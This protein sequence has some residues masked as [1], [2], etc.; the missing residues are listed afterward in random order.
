MFD[1][2]RNNGMLQLMDASMTLASKR[3]TLIAS[4]LANID[5]PGFHTRDFS[6][7]GA[8]KSALESQAGQQSPAAMKLTQ[9]GHQSPSASTSLPPSEDPIW[10][11]WER[12][13]GNDV[14]L[15]RENMLLARTQQTYQT[16]SLFMQAQLRQLYY[17]IREASK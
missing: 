7:Q 16:A 14:N 10:P 13:D 9:A 3:Q 4:N 2:T 17:A 12:N 1:I 15:D 8:L 11:S 6:F 5:T